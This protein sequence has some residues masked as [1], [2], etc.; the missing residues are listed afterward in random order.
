MSKTEFMWE[1]FRNDAI[2]VWCKTEIEA[3]EFLS[4]CKNMGYRFKSGAAIG[5]VTHWEIN[6]AQTLYTARYDRPEIEYHGSTWVRKHGYIIISA[7]RVFDDLSGAG[8]TPREELSDD[9]QVSLPKKCLCP[10]WRDA[11]IDRPKEDGRYLV[12]TVIAIG[13]E[14]FRSAE[15]VEFSNETGWAS[16][17]SVVTHWLDGVPEL[18]E[19]IVR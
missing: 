9:F 8:S 4:L 10:A 2:A 7:K 6:G 1:N 16:S 12:G 14:L 17:E 18:P 5:D 3:R 15:L 13:G 19:V 11:V